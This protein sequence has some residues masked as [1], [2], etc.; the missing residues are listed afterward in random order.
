MNRIIIDQ[1]IQYPHRE[2]TLFIDETRRGFEL[3]ISYDN[4]DTVIATGT[5]E[6]MKKEARRQSTVIA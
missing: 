2:M 6:E 4:Q 1:W 5:R 3:V